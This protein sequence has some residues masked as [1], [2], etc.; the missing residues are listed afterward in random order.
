M[1]QSTK[2]RV[3]GT[4]GLVL[5]ALASVAWYA[6]HRASSPAR[7]PDVVVI[8][9]DTLRASYLNVYGYERETAPFLSELAERSAVFDRA[10]STSSWTAP[11]TASIFTGRYPWS[12]GIKIGFYLHLNWTNTDRPNESTIPLN[13]FSTTERTLPMRFQALGYSTLGMAS[14]INIGDEIGFS[15]G[16]DRFLLEHRDAA[17]GLRHKLAYWLFETRADRPI[18]VYLHLNDCHKP[19][20]K[21]PQYFSEEEARGREDRSRYLSE[22]RYTDAQLKSIYELVAGENTLFVVLSDHGEEFEDHGGLGHTAKLYDELNRVLMMIHGPDLGIASRRFDDI[23]VS[24]I[25]VLPTL[26]ELVGEEA[27]ADVEGT[28]LARLVRGEDDGAELRDRVQDRVLFAHRRGVRNQDLWAAIEGPWKLIQLSDGSLELYDHRSD[29]EER[30]D[31]SDARAAIASRMSSL[32]EPIRERTLASSRERD[33]VEL[34]VDEE[35][36]RTLK[37]LGYVR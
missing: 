31:V 1:Q 3:L 36:E 26:L 9:V 27:P 10:F 14:N 35:L 29:P 25:D 11:S 4:S 33:E 34:E 21:R 7:R 16:F 13:R 15:R 23:N 19:Y 28:S 20:S 17:Q 6:L 37:S 22:I 2:R 30:N 18:F 12:H 32:L 24:L 5:V 8:V